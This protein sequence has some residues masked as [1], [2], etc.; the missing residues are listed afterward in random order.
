[1]DTVCAKDMSQAAGCAPRIIGSV[2]CEHSRDAD[3]RRSLTE[4]TWGLLAAL[5]ILPAQTGQREHLYTHS[6]EVSC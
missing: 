6:A 3:V 4:Q 2:L 5:R 1:M